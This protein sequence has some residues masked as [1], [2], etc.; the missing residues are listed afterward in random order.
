MSLRIHIVNV[1]FPPTSG[2]G[3]WRALSLANAMAA[4]GHQVHFF[5]SSHSPWHDRQDPSLL[6]RVSGD[7]RVSRVRSVFPRDI[8]QKLQAIGRRTGSSLV[9]RLAAGIEWRIEGL[10]PDPIAL[11]ALQVSLRTLLASY[12]QRPDIVITT[13]PD[14]PVHLAG[15]LLSRLRGVPWVMEYRDPWNH[16]SDTAPRAPGFGRRLMLRAEKAFLER[17]SAVVVVS[18]TWLAQIR[19]RFAIADAERFHVILNGHE[20]DVAAEP[21]GEPGGGSRGEDFAGLRVHFNGKIQPNNNLLE[22]L[23]R[24]LLKLA[25]AP[26][27]ERR[28]RFTFCGLPEE[29]DGPAREARDK[30]L[31]HDFGPLSHAESLQRCRQADALMVVVKDDEAFRGAIPAKTYEAMATGKFV[32]GLVPGEGDVRDILQEYPNS[33]LGRSSD[34]DQIEGAIE[35]LHQAWRDNGSMLPVLPPQTRAPFV[36]KYH[37]RNRNRE[38]AA[39]ID[40]LVGGRKRCAVGNAEAG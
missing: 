40:D 1:D 39:L 19:E 27:A 7:I 31:I 4:A 8:R 14:H 38:Y 22:P 36:D 29:L 13:G 30:G 5:C 12:R 20:L 34:V 33:I 37:R 18:K 35:A 3:V 32:L 16:P 2:P 24:A 25:A 9:R 23:S 28:L 15:Y 21:A 6:A 17:A 10:L 11:F 26:G